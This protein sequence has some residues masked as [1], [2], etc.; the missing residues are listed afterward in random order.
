MAVKDFKSALRYTKNQLPKLGVDRTWVHQFWLTQT[1]EGRAVRSAGTYGSAD[2]HS[3][4]DSLFINVVVCDCQRF[5]FG[6]VGDAAANVPEQPA[7]DKE[8]DGCLG[9][10]T[11]RRMVTWMEFVEGPDEVLADKV[12]EIEPNE[13][14]V[15]AGDRIPVEGVQIVS[16]DEPGGLDLY[17]K[18]KK[19]S[20]GKKKGFTAWPKSIMDLVGKDPKFARL[21]GFLHWDAGWSA[22]GAMRALIARGLGSAIGTDRPRKVDGQVIAY[23]WLDPGLYYGWHG[24]AANPRSLVSFD[25][26]NAVYL[27]Y[28]AKYTKLCG[29]ERPKLFISSREKVGSG[30]GFLGMY[31]DQILTTLRILKALSNHVG[32]PLV[33]PV[34]SKDGRSLGRNYKR[35]FKDDFHG[36]ASHRHLPSTTKWD[37]R[38]FEAQVSALLL[39]DSKLMAEFPSLVECFRLHDDWRGPW[40]DQVKAAWEWKEL[41]G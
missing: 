20:R 40:L 39:S 35:L 38:G 16:F 27:K 8:V 4:D 32:L 5:V 41:W 15:F 36:V 24:S 21:L 29:I 11:H 18:A 30:K 17:A 19:N 13:Y 28:H 37:V 31:R 33:F 26:S 34:R 22:E 1:S 6:D 10:M 3:E 14:I 12:P 25:L 7:T 2:V 9:S 23:Q